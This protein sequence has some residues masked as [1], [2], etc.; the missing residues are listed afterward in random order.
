MKSPIKCG[1]VKIDLFE[2]LGDTRDIFVL[3]L[4]LFLPMIHGPFF[5]LGWQ[6]V[7]SFWKLRREISNMDEDEAC[8]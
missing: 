4:F 8:K 5:S 7:I 6:C 1:R 2:I 3:F